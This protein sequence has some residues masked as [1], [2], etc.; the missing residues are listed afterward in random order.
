RARLQQPPFS[1]QANFRERDQRWQEMLASFHADGNALLSVYRYAVGLVGNDGVLHANFARVLEFLGD[2]NAAAA[3]WTEVAQLIP[4]SPQAW[5][6]LGRLAH[7]M[8]DRPKAEHFLKEGLRR[9]PDS[10]EIMTE[11]G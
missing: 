1:S 5:F 10:V 9:C 6:H 11:M 3:Q 4:D 8:G 7:T 2:R